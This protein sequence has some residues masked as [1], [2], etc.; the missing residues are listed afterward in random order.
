MRTLPVTTKT[1]ERNLIDHPVT[2]DRWD[3]KG[4]IVH[5]FGALFDVTKDGVSLGYRLP[6]VVVVD[7]ERQIWMRSPWLKMHRSKPTLLRTAE[8]FIEQI[9]KAG[10]PLRVDE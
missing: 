2:G 10:R 8:Q 7:G 9:E 1:T 4:K 6:I 5:V 3:Y